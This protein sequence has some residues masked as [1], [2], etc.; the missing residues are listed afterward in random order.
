M[1]ETHRLHGK[2]PWARL[3]EPAIRLARD[4]FAVSPRLAALIAADQNRLSQHPSTRAYFFTPD[5]RPLQAGTTL[6]NAAYADTLE[7]IAQR[8]ADA[9]YTGDIANDIVNAVREHPT[10]PGVLATRDLETYRIA[11]REPVCGPYRSYEVCGMGPPSSGG[12]TLLQILGMAEH[13]NMAGFGQGSADAAH[14]LAE[15]GRL[16][17]ADRAIY[18]AD[19]DAVPVPVRGLIDSAYLT[20]RAQ[21]IDL[22]KAI[23]APKAGNPPW[24]DARLWGPDNALEFPSTSHVSIVD[25]DNNIVS[26]TTTIEDAFGARMMVRGFLLNNE[27]TDFAFAP[28]ANGRPVANAVAPGKRPRSSMAPTIV[29]DREGEPVI[30]IGSPG[31]ARI[32]GYVASALVGLID[33]RLDPAAAVSQ[34]HM[35]T[36]GRTVELEEGT[37][38]AALEAPLRARGHTVQVRELNSGLGIIVRREGRLVGAAD[39]RREGIALGD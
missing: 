34:P 20:L 3:F 33:W 25:A 7:A 38:V 35:L 28:V 11:V 17:F 16:A 31:G 30:V 9:F 32:I 12:L 22:D 36:L 27:L 37:P 23:E 13:F 1:A 15:A 21:T 24:R 19:A 4:G 2:L 5:G 39:P 18:M 8:G 29:F 14:V 10:N 26:M 6:V